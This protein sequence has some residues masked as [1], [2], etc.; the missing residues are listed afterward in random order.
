MAYIKTIISGASPSSGEVWS[1]G[2]NWT[3]AGVLIPQEDMTAIATAFGV[4]IAASSGNALI[5][6][7]SSAG[8][9][10]RIRLEQRNVSDEN[11]LLAAEY[12]LPV[13]ETGANTPS[14]TLQTSIC[15]SLLTNVPGRSY[16]G[17]VYWPA[18]TY[19]PTAGL[20]FGTG[21]CTAALTGFAALMNMFKVACTSVDS[22]YEAELVVRSRLLHE[23]NLVISY[24]CGTVPDTQRRRRDAVTEVYSTLAA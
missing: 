5:G 4:A 9:I 7:L 21:T 8:N 20:L 11:L 10:N 12:G 15:I 14:S 22:F 16:R 18:W 19:A 17:R 6:M 1:V 2:T 23:S 3:V 24:A 13:P